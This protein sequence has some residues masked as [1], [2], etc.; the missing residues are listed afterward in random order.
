MK[1]LL[2]SLLLVFLFLTLTYASTLVELKQA[3][4]VP[5]PVIMLMF[6]CGLIGLAGIKKS[7]SFKK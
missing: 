5:G 6:G 4:S 7:K 1:K 2:I 3:D